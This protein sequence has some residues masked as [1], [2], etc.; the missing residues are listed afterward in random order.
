MKDWY[1][2]LEEHIASIQR[3]VGL[4]DDVVSSYTEVTQPIPLFQNVWRSFGHVLKLN[5][6]LKLL[7]LELQALFSEVSLH[8]DTGR[9]LQSALETNSHFKVREP[10]PFDDTQSAKTLEKFLWGINH[11]FKAMKVPKVE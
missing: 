4:L 8:K 2:H 11:N 10:S 9:V 3:A 7:T 6:N 1:D 5:H